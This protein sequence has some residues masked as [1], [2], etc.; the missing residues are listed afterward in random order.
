MLLLSLIFGF[1]IFAI[2]LFISSAFFIATGDNYSKAIFK[3]CAAFGVIVVFFI[4]FALI[5]E[6]F[7]GKMHVSQQDIYGTYVIDRTMF[8][9]ENA[10]WQYNHFRIEVTKS[11]SIKLYV[12]DGEKINKTHTSKI[13]FTLDNRPHIRIIAD[14]LQHPILKENPTLYRKPFSF[15]YVF[16]SPLYGNMFFTKG[17]YE[18]ID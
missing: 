5:K 18:E 2:F 7:T 11:D 8:P 14:S 15:Y 4:V 17:E 16:E 9:G 10:D 13:E 12:T 6:Y 1:F 3:G